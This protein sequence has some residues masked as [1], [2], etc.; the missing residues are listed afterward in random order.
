MCQGLSLALS[1]YELMCFSQQPHEFPQMRKLRPGKA[2]SRP[3][4]QPPKHPP[5]HL[6]VLAM[7]LPLTWVVHTCLD[8]IVQSEAG[9]SLLVPQLLVEVRGQHLGHMVVV[10]AEVRVFL[11][12][13][14][15]QL[16][17]VVGVTER[18]G[19]SVGG[20]L[21]GGGEGEKVSSPP[22]VTSKATEQ[23]SGVRQAGG[24]VLT[25]VLCD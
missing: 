7:L 23:G 14:V 24:P 12:W 25:P 6:P 4:R 5:P 17:F 13:L 18:H 9:R 16:I 2:G 19:D 15:I 21:G 3:G 11:L 8:D 20:A 10:L 1:T 22:A